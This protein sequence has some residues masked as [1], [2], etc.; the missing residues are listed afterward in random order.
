MI[1]LILLFIINVFLL[2]GLVLF[3]GC[4]EQDQ[5]EQV[6]GSSSAESGWQDISE[7]PP[8]QSDDSDLKILYVSNPG[9]ERAKDFTDFLVKHFKTVNTGDLE[10]FKDSDSDD[11]DVTILDY[12]GDGFEAPRPRLSRNFS[13]PLLTVGVI[14][15]FICDSMGLKTG[16]L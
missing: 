9:S 8:M 14:G 6:T 16:Y 2:V 7:I 12:D 5:S 10:S 13:K 1:R 4:K 3:Q 15:A 11:F